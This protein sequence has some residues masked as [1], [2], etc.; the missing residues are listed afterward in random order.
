MEK[1]LIIDDE[2]DVVEVLKLALEG[3]GFEVEKAF[4]GKEGIE[5]FE[6][7]KPDL[8]VLDILMEDIDGINVRKQLPESAKVIVISACDKKT[9]EAIEKEIKCEKWLEKPFKIQEL[10]EEVKKLKQE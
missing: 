4:S 8:V 3:E 9:K 1:I 10:V 7:F 5:K 2:P 6:A